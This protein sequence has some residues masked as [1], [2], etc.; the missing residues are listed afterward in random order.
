[1]L[2][3]SAGHRPEAQGASYMGFSEWPEAMKWATEIVNLMPRESLLVPTGHLR[4]KVKFINEHAPLLAVEIHFNSAVNRAGKHVGEG[5]ESLYCPGSK[6]GKRLAEDIQKHLSP[7]F[8]PDRGAKEGWYQMNP[9]NGPDFFLKAT[10]CPAVIIEPEFI[11]HKE[12][13]TENR[14]DGCRAI[15]NAIMEWVNN[16]K[17]INVDEG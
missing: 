10:I 5:S 15:V 14:T 12:K 8:K 13:I 16:T 9:A 1:M 17:I 7:L 4:E 2:L 6:K 11:Q 3:I